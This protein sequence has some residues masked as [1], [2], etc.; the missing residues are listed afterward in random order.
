MLPRGTKSIARAVLALR[1]GSRNTRARSSA[2]LW[3]ACGVDGYPFAKPGQQRILLKIEPET[4][5][6]IGLDA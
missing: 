2:Q 1:S 4:I 3:A 5:H 6:T